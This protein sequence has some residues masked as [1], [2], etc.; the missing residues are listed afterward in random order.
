MGF[1]FLPSHL[2]RTSPHCRGLTFGVFQV[3]SLGF[4]GFRV[5]G[6]IEH[7]NCTRLSGSK[8]GAVFPKS[9]ELHA[10]CL[11]QCIGLKTHKHDA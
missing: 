8:P 2:A 3:W 7:T 6:F 4:R 11:V 10:L 5:F 1:G 9:Q